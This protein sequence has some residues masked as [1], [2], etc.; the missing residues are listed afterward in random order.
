MPEPQI[1][2]RAEQ[3]FWDEEH[4]ANLELPARPHDSMPFERC[5]ARELARYAAVQVGATV[6]E[7]GCTPARWLVFYAERFG[8]K[9]EGVEYTEKGV[10][11]SRRNLELIG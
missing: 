3:D 6:L 4:F 7:V 9:V 5:L 2:N 10:E 1:H 8:A 11:L